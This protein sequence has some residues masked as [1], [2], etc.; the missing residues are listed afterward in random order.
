ML[1]PGRVWIEPLL[2]AALEIGKRVREESVPRGYK[3]RSPED[4]VNLLGD[5]TRKLNRE[6]F[7][8]LRLD[9]KNTLMGRPEDVTQGIL[10]ASLVHP[11]EVF[12]R[13]I[14]EAAAAIVLVHNHP[15]GSTKPSK[16]DIEI[17]KQLMEVSKVVGI[18]LL[19]HVIVTKHRFASIV[20]DEEA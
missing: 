4:A 11:R 6:I 1:W 13:A 15:S 8:V 7:W 19:D 18:D 20:L 10:D 12:R 2:T 9:T 17:T 5:R 16:A 3:V 14:R